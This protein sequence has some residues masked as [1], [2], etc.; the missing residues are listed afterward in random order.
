MNE[1][2]CVCCK[3]VYLGIIVLMCWFVNWIIVFWND[4]ISLIMYWICFLVYKC[5]FVVIWLLWLWLVC[6]FLLV[7]LICWIS[8]C[9]ILRWIFLREVLNL[10]LFFL[11]LFWIF[12]S[13]LMMDWVLLFVIICCL[14]S[15]VV[16][17]ILFWIFCLIKFLLKLIDVL[18]LLIYFLGWVLNLLF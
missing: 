2:G 1:M 14:V 17:V 8:L 4:V 16:C 6:S 15:I 11:K 7:L 5:I 18:K 12:L 3:C 9:L 13:L 10:S